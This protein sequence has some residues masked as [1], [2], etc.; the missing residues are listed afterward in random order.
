[1]DDKI[2]HRREIGNDFIEGN[3][4]NACSCGWE[5]EER[6]PV[7]GVVQQDESVWRRH[8]DAASERAS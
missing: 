2:E 1:M 5:S 7:L 3:Y 4:F 8:V 6:Y